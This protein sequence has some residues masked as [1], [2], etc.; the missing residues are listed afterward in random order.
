[1]VCTSHLAYFF[2]CVST[3][4][5]VACHNISLLLWSPE[6]SPLHLVAFFLCPDR[7]L[8]PQAPS[9]QCP[10]VAFNAC[11]LALSQWHIDLTPVV[12]KSPVQSSFSTQ[13]GL[14]Q[15]RSENALNQTGLIKTG[16]YR[17]MCGPR[18]SLHE[19]RPLFSQTTY[20]V[21]KSAIILKNDKNIY[22]SGQK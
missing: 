18:T 14:N 1:M 16:L 17:S 13:I 9:C 4:H 20:H 12:F 19:S 10:S 3:P 2:P 15:D 5:K 7:S 6:V 21:E 11:L 8:L 22:I